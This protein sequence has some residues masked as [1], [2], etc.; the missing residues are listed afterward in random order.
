MNP[1]RIAILFHQGDR[2]RDTA[3]YAI[4]HFSQYW[5][6]DGHSVVRLFG[7]KRVEP[8]DILIVHV[9]LS[10]VPDEY[11]EFASR[12]PIALNARIRDIRKSSFA[13]NRAAPGD[14]WDGP[15][16]VKSDL[17]YA[18]EPERRLQRTWLER[19]WQ[20]ARRAR[21]LY[22]R[23]T[24]NTAP[25][26]TSADYD[27]YDSIDD[28]PPGVFDDSRVVVERF[29]PEVENDLYHMTMYQFL[30]D[31]FTCTRFASPHPIISAARSVSAAEVE[32]HHGILE[33]REKLTIDYGKL[34]YV[35]HNDKVVL[36][37]ANKT[38]GM[39]VYYSDERHHRLRRNRAE[40]LYYYFRNDPPG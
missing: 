2:Y 27:V 29:C 23:M 21:R 12:Y 17:N 10:V 31:R 33:W 39:G 3:C 30:G 32:P 28:V 25:F 19:K 7:V 26:G 34:D 16:I 20:P 14:G 37:D 24:G 15:V 18:G 38:T 8:A 40:G 5:E 1:K 22:D 9:N 35:V 4:H 6:A 13:H 11:I 36:L